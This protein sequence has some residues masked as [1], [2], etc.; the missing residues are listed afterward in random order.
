MNFLR[1]L[2]HTLVRI[3]TE[4]LG[5]N[6]VK[7]KELEREGRLTIGPHTAAYSLP[8][9]KTYT[10]DETRLEIGDYCSLS[11]EAIFQL[12]GQHGIRTVGTYP[13]K[14]LWGMEGAGQDGHPDRSR[15]TV[16]V[17]GSDVYLTDGAMV[18]G[19]VHI[20]HGVVVGSGAIVTKDIPDYA[21]V[22]GI[23]A[24][25]IGWRHTEEQR[26]ALL[27]IAWWDWPEAEVRAAADLLGREDVDAF[28]AY[29]RERFPDGY[30]RRAP[31]EL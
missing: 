7:I 20:G 21:I 8:R 24:K 29:A 18:M 30:P 25:I 13:H 3:R 5:P 4:L 1:F 12:G 11:T 14:I 26:A 15:P 9:I 19:G 10:H 27:E 23:P 2:W 22:G 16:T 17:V 31:G 6:R 28:I